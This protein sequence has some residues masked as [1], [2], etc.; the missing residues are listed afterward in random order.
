VIRTSTDSFVVR[1]RDTRVITFKIADSTVFFHGSKWSKQARLRRGA[2]VSV[3]S[4][5]DPEGILTADE[6]E[7]RDNLPPFKF[8]V[9]AAALL[10]GG[11]K[12]DHLVEKARQASEQLFQLL[13]NFVC[14][15]STTRSL[16]GADHHWR[17]MDR[18]TAEVLY[19]HGHE[20]YREVKLNG[21]PTGRSIM[22]LPGSRS[23]GEFGSSLRALFDRD[24]EA[25]FR[26]QS[27][28]VLSGYYTAI[29]E[30]AVAGDKSDWR[31]TAGSQM[32]MTPYKGRIWIDRDSGNV[33]RIEMKAVEIP[34]SFPFRRVEAEVDYGPVILPSGRYFLP[35]QADNLSCNDP[36]SC[37]RNR[38]E[39]RNYQKYIGEST[40]SFEPPEKP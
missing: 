31:I 22:D 7:F 17:E 8:P 35:Q 15:Q 40:I 14:Q 12:I 4:S 20:S 3:E 1:A 18:I 32:L 23:T 10:P 24:T 37:S 19:E 29:Y 33:L 30:F 13:P 21:K 34:E 11:V 38:I 28:A 9:K 6:V 27:N 25:L 36:Q 26:F 16:A 2:L 5:A 39:F